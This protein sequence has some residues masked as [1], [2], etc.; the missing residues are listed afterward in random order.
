MSRL[1]KNFGTVIA[2][3]E[4][5]FH[6]GDQP[7]ALYLIHRGKIQITKRMGDEEKI[8]K[9]L[10]EGEFVGEMAVIDSLTRSASAVA[11]EECELIRME[12]ASF[13]KTINKNHKFAMSFIHCL[14]DRLRFT[15]ESVSTLYQLNQLQD[16]KLKILTE[17][18][19]NGKRAK[20]GEWILLEL[21]PLIEQ[22]TSKY[23]Y[24]HKAAIHVLEKLDEQDDFSYKKDQKGTT[25]IGYRV[26]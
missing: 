22:L 24:E 21:E 17:F 15:N 2:A 14:S 12:K 25:W 8:L 6:E 7:D 11:L 26:K 18:I 16:I 10:N 23:Y 4:Y 9:I 5:I 3:G 1:L 13:D 19:A 20:N